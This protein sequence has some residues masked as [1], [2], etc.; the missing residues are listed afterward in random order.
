MSE[1]SAA[2]AS[3][4]TEAARASESKEAA[5]TRAKTG[6]ARVELG[7]ALALTALA[8][9]LHFTFLLRAGGLWRDEVVSFNVATQPTLD[10]VH[11]AVRYD[12]FPSLFHL[13]LR[14]WLSLGWGDPDLGTRGLGFLM[15]A[16]VLGALWWNAR[17]F[18]S[19]LPLLSLL[20][21]GVSGLC[22][23]TTDAI[24]AYGIGILCIT[25]CFGAIWRVATRPS[26]VNVLV[27]GAA[28]IL[29]V[30]ALY[31]NAFL[32][33]AVCGAGALITA[34]H[35][36]WRRAALIL[37]VGA[38]AA[39]S[40]VL[41]LE[42]MQQMGEVKQLI[43]SSAGM[44]RILGVAMTALRDGSNLRLTLWL[45][46]LVGFLV[47]GVHSL[48]V[49]RRESGSPEQE[50][51][52][53][54]VLYT[55]AV[56]VI[57][58]AGFLLWLRVLGFPTQVW[59]YVAPM[60]LCALALDVAWPALLSSYKA[61]VARV[62]VVAVGALLGLSSAFQAVNVRQTNVD[63]IAA[64]LQQL[65]APGDFIL[66]DQWFNGATFSRYFS[67]PTPWTTLPP[68]EDQTLQRLD[69]FKQYMMAL[70]PTAPVEQRMID[71]LKAGNRVWLAGGLPFSAKDK[72]APEL[73]PAP[74]SAVGWDHD[75]YS[76]IWAR[77]AGQLLQKGAA[78]AAR[79]DLQLKAPVNELEN[80][81]L[82]V[83]QGW[84]GQ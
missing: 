4:G 34:R 67:G 63:L 35:G 1:M 45:V 69:L 22:V 49:P 39:L 82:W 71:T 47:L 44:D 70:R 55:L 17:V 23:R 32:L 53:E 56:V 27:A 52:R 51:E 57:A 68:L 28:A 10:A 3:G 7:T 80:L 50:V 2:L 75:A 61:S 74:N 18:N 38:S 54:V 30:Q 81:P 16:S 25:L 48:G 40:L 60:V 62:S 8:V 59:Y 21:V 29:S 37:G 20:L 14:S 64:R 41:Y 78:Q 65:A 42:A 46:L 12:S 24:R 19:R 83:L 79:V 15:G 73:P 58:I 43:A 77:R 11:E 76:Y 72:P 66:V 31:Q 13:I 33:V 5:S 9:T 6:L 26:R 36:L 84:K